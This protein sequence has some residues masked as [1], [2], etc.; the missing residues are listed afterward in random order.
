MKVLA[1]DSS[2]TSASVAL[3]DNEFILG[4]FYINTS[5]T[6]S[7]T[8]MM[9]IKS[10]LDNTK[11]NVEDIDAFAVSV[12]P[13]SFTGVRIGVSA[14]KGMAYA[15]NKPCIP[16]STLYAMAFNLSGLGDS[17]ICAVMDARCNQVYN[18]FFNIFNGSIDRIEE[19]RAIKIEDLKNDILNKYNNKI[20]NLVGDGANLCYNNLNKE[21]PNLRLLPGHLLYQRAYG[22]SQA[23]INLYNKGA[24]LSASDLN[25]VYLR[26]PQAQ[27]ELRKKSKLLF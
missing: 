14:I 4:E 8:L 20:I 15:L 10:L 22:V 23:G 18:A 13:G 9:M 6:H 19:D 1:L 27:R 12:G 21:I 25:P 2:A 17:L 26:M 16:V 11:T 3:V 7:Q 24:F 5:L